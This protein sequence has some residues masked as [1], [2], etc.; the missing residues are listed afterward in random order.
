VLCCWSDIHC[1]MCDLTGILCE[2]VSC[3]DDERAAR[4]RRS[5]STDE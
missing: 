1:F 2:C 3:E 4:P 5:D